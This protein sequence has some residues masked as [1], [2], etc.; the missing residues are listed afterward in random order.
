MQGRGPALV[1]IPTLCRGP[2]TVLE[3]ELVALHTVEGDAEVGLDHLARPHEP[4]VDQS[5]GRSTT[6]NAGNPDVRDERAEG[7][8][9]LRLR[10]N[11]R[12]RGNAWCKFS[13]RRLGRGPRGAD[14]S[15][16]SGCHRGFGV[17]DSVRCIDNLAVSCG[18][19]LGL[20]DGVGGSVRQCIHGRRWGGTGIRCGRG[21]RHR[22]CRRL[23]SRCHGS[24]RR[25]GRRRYDKEHGP[26]NVAA[27]EKKKDSGRE[28]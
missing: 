12:S 16:R 14:W 9:C 15:R 28:T 27:D 13:R 11:L 25:C 4:A 20:V 17:H 10:I 8:A 18:R 1:S 2:R 19:S 21:S 23:G 22:R 6:D 24:R 3:D 7:S 26:G 5:F